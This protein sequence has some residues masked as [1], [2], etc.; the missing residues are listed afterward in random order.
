M[1]QLKQ[2]KGLRMSCDAG[3]VTERLKNEQS[4]VGEAKEG[5]ENEL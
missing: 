1:T 3:E 2:R 4:D 5:F